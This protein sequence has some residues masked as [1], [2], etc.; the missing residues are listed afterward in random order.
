MRPLPVAQAVLVVSAAEVMPPMPV[1]PDAAMVA[2]YADMVFGWCEGW[3]AV[4][5]LAE[6]GGPDR[7]PHTPFLPADT[8]L[9]AKLAVQAQWAAEA[10]MALYV[11]PGTVAAPGQAS[12]EHVTQMQVVLVDLDGGDIAA[13]R[14]HLIRHLGPPSLEVASGGVTPEG[15]EKLH[16]YWRLT[17]PATGEDLATVCRLRHAI[18]V[19]VGGD[20]AFRSAHQPIRVAG[21]IHAK[22][23]QQRL[24]AIRHSA[25][26]DHDLTELAEA[27]LAMPPLPGVGAELSANADG[28][29]LDFNAA[30]TARG[31]VTELFGQQVREG[32]ADG[33]TRFEAL[34]RIIGYWIRRCQDGFVTAAQAW[35]EI[36]DYNAARIS[37]PW[38]ED[39]LRQEAERLSRRA[40]AGNNAARDPATEDATAGGGDSGD[41][42]LLP[43]GFTEDAL[44]AEF[45]ALHGEDWRHVAVWGAWLTWTGTRWER[46][47]TLRAF[48]LA[49]RVCRA[50]A[51][52]ANNAKVRTKLSQASTVSAVERLARADRRHATTAEVWDRDPWLLNTPSGVV[53]LRSGALAPHDRTL[54]MTKITAAASGG[55]CPAWLAFLA[56]VT[57]SDAELQAYL[58]RVVGYALTGVTTEHALFFLYGTGANG[59]SVFANTLTALLGD[60]AAVAPMDMFMA[61]TG[62]RHPTDMAGLRGARIVTSIETEQGSRWAESKLKALTGGDRITARFMRQDFFEFTPQF[63]LLVAGNHKPSIRNVDEAMRRRLHMVPF[64]VTIPPAQRDKRLPERL[65]AER[66]GILAWA[67]QGCLEWQRIGLRPPATV[68]AATDEYFEA[69]DALGRWISDCCERDAQGVE[70]TAAL[71]ASWRIW[72]EANGEFVGSIKRFS[73]TLSARGF[74]PHRT[75]ATR[76]FLGLRLRDPAAAT[77]YTSNMEF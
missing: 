11:I 4:R 61:T 17:E 65:L 62:D 28:G 33:V 18:A 12:A 66:D 25:G 44:A 7:A 51:N 39:R 26:R 8:D 70:S 47:G 41:D 56:Q 16:L 1:A 14:A 53:D 30:A 77:P 27:V 69:E 75:S 19:K 46:E 48:D 35:Q 15:Q 20:P 54:S 5:A 63:K 29:P 2:A 38:P 64:T 68:L 32:G 50:A 55:D 22:G 43:I 13:K 52:R 24:V 45:S 42:G 37:P 31:D 10:G 58:R 67:L 57:G 76:S 59:K 71:Y 49:R 34:S 3:V 40:E 21:S 74:A 6:K 72:A 23:G 73:Q 9:P 60:Y 36:C